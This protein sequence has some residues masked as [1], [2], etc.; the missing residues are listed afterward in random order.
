MVIDDESGFTVYTVHNNGDLH[1]Y[2]A[3]AMTY[4]FDKVASV[5]SEKSLLKERI[6][7]MQIHGDFL[8]V[9]NEMKK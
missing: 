8:V 2:Y 7:L 9:L 4:L 5:P 3:T 1:K 6:D